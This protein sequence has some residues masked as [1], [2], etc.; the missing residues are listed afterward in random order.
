MYIYMTVS[1]LARDK[2]EEGADGGKDDSDDEFRMRFFEI[3]VVGAE[4]DEIENFDSDD[5]WTSKVCVY[6][7][8]A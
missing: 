6:V 5:L 7:C 2:D 1:S 3:P 8:C 4:W